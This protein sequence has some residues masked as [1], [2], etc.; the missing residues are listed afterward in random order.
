M[1]SPS[2]ATD[3]P[4]SQWWNQVQCQLIPPRAHFNRGFGNKKFSLS[5]ALWQSL[6]PKEKA[7]SGSFSNLR[8]CGLPPRV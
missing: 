5:W 1:T 3:H 6:S 8:L 7:I 4:T 2:D